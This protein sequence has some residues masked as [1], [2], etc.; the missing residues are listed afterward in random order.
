MLYTLRLKDTNGNCIEFIGSKESIVKEFN[1]L[2]K[3]EQSEIKSF[4][5]LDKDDTD[6]ETIILI[7]EVGEVVKS[8]VIPTMV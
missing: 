3:M 8:F 2:K 6:I 4:F 1:M 7:D 5:G